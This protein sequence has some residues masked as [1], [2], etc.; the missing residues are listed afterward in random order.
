MFFRPFLERNEKL[1]TKQQKRN[2]TTRCKQENHLVLL[3]KSR[4]HKHEAIQLHCLDWIHWKQTTQ[5]QKK[6]IKHKSKLPSNQHDSKNTR[7]VGKNN[8]FYSLKAKQETKQKQ[9]IT[10]ETHTKNK[11]NIKQKSRTMNHE[12]K[13][14]NNWKKNKLPKMKASWFWKGGC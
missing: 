2:K 6:H 1:K 4:Q 12:D 7:L 10:K 3:Q 5:E 11:A 8:V 14:K 9:T 13:N